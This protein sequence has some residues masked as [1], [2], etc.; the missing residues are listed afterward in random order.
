MLSGIEP[1]PASVQHKSYYLVQVYSA[2]ITTYLLD[3]KTTRP[4]DTYKVYTLPANTVYEDF[5]TAKTSIVQ[6]IL[7]IEYGSR[8]ANLIYS[9][10]RFCMNDTNP[11]SKIGDYGYGHEL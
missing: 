8:I 10:M 11:S 9:Q 5:T 6:G 4:D 1:Y 3:I 7:N 2:P